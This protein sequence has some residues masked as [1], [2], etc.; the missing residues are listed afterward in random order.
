MHNQQEEK[1]KKNSA[2]IPI[3]LKPNSPLVAGSD[4]HLVNFRSQEY[5]LFFIITHI[6]WEYGLF[7]IIT[8]ILELLMFCCNIKLWCY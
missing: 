7:F 4:I 2:Q 8:H 6:L 5:G 1:K 3:F